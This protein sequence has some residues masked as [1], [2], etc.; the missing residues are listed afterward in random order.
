AQADSDRARMVSAGIALQRVEEERRVLEEYT[1]RINTKKLDSAIEEAKRALDRVQ[2]QAVGKIAGLHADRSAKYS[3]YL[4][5]QAKVRDLEE[6]IRKCTLRAP[7][8][9]L[10]VYYIPEQTR[11]GSGTQQAIVAQGEPVRE[12]QKLMSIPNL[13]RMLVNTRVHEAMISKVRGDRM[14]R[15]GFS[16]A[17]D[18]ATLLS[19]DTPFAVAFTELTY[20]AKRM[21]VSDAYREHNE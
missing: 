16:D 10:V 19:A 20:Q 5:Q 8:A 4:Q 1:A 2:K 14:V 9:G 6:E 18:A 17:I 3:T 7:Q 15:T 21:D 12:G 13:S 11:S